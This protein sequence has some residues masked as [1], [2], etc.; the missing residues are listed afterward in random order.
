LAAAC[1]ERGTIN[2]G[3]ERGQGQVGT[4]Q[5]DMEKKCFLPN[6]DCGVADCTLERVTCRSAAAP[7]LK[8]T[9][10]EE[11]DAVFA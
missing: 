8:H 6:E 3:L 1:I 5:F 4:S 2:V 10:W 7:T 9:D 11:K